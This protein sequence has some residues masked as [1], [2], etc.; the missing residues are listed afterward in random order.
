[1][2]ILSLD[3][4]TLGHHLL[5][6]PV[7]VHALA[8]VAADPGCAVSHTRAVDLTGVVPGAGVCVGDWECGGEQG[9]IV[10]V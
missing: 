5:R 3:V 9:E 4:R 2:G 8:I 7:D 1:M 6:R 10:R